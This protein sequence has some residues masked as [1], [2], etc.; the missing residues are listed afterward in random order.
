MMLFSFTAELWAM[1]A[2]RPYNLNARLM[3]ELIQEDWKK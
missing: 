3:A 1:P 2:A